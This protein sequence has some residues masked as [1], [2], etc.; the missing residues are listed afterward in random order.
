MQI[1]KINMLTMIQTLNQTA[2]GE[3]IDQL[4]GSYDTNIQNQ[5]TAGEGNYPYQ[6]I[7]NG[8]TQ[9]QEA[10]GNGMTQNQLADNLS[11]QMSGVAGNGNDADQYS[12][13]F[14]NQNQTGEYCK[15]S[16]KSIINEYDRSRCWYH[17]RWKLYH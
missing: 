8:T 11:E 1:H 16:S 14:N 12:Y 15:C 6:D 9:N 7:Y 2:E 17:W 4:Q 13:N 3:L 10:A 5:Q